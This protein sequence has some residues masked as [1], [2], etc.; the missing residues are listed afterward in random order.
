LGLWQ[1]IA[2]KGLLHKISA[3]STNLPRKE[4]CGYRKTLQQRRALWLFQAALSPVLRFLNRRNFLLLY[5]FNILSIQGEFM[6]IKYRHDKNYRCS[7]YPTVK[8]LG[9]NST[10]IKTWFGFTA[11]VTVTTLV[12][13]CYNAGSKDKGTDTAL[14]G[15]LWVERVSGITEDFIR[16]VDISSVLAAEAAGVIY[17]D[18]NGA[19]QDIFKI[20]A[21]AGVNYIRVRV[22]NDPYIRQWDRDRGALE[23][24]L[25]KSY[26]GGN[27]DAENARKIG[28]RIVAVNA[29]A[30]AD[31]KL[32]VDFHYSDFWADPGRQR[33]PKA[34]DGMDI[35]E[36]KTAIAEWTEEALTLIASSGVSIGMVQIG[37]EINSGI[38]GEKGNDV[39]D[40]LKSAGAAVRR[41]S[42]YARVVVHYT[43]PEVVDAHINRA[44]ALAENGV[45]YDIFATSY[46]PEWHG[47]LANLKTEL[48]KVKNAYPDKDIL[49]AEYG[50]SPGAGADVSYEPLNEGHYPATVQGQATAMRDAIAAAVEIGAIGLCYYEPA[51]VPLPAHNTVE[52]WEKYGYG[53]A[54]V[55]ARI[56]DN[57][58]VSETGAPDSSRT[59]FSDDG[60]PRLSLNVFRYVYSGQQDAARG[61]YV[62]HLTNA[63]V[64]I[65][66]ADAASAASR[67]PSAVTANY[68][69]GKTKEVAVDWDK[70]GITAVSAAGRY[71]INGTAQVDGVMLAVLCHV[72]VEGESAIKGNVLANPG[73]EDADMSLWTL[74]T[75]GVS[76]D[77]HA[78]R[79]TEDPYSGGYGFHFWSASAFEFTIEQQVMV[80][81]AGKYYFSFYAQG[82]LADGGTNIYVKNAA[83]T[84]LASRDFSL[85]GWLAWQY[86]SGELELPAGAVTVGVDF[87]G[88]AGAWGTFDDFVLGKQ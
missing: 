58:N 53:W 3:F 7:V 28:E 1:K 48:T 42:P 59:L 81:D 80:S 4:V 31:I 83:G 50:S 67:I 40:L 63:A 33:V 51:W 49:I 5:G 16:G 32:L 2:Y 35:D 29:A 36:K 19:P 24:W 57:A 38:A 62:V 88:R 74:T 73:F 86:P 14:V 66:E 75:S 44:K 15:D 79:R 77:G 37:N 72:T 39:F 34:W 20:L 8:V 54:N 69:S 68:A 45:D 12:L 41:I 84:I 85:A 10:V 18:F 64:S 76:N 52:T 9:Y 82:N 6:V 65:S 71:D 43:N 27:C 23:E 26:G 87:K 60:S 11:L 46:Y 70:A 55:F 25:G 30:G 78:E 22:W 17:R 61:D 56:Y 47:T 13:G 21:E